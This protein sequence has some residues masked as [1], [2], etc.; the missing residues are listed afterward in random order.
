M[1]GGWHIETY[2]E[3]MLVGKVSRLLILGMILRTRSTATSALWGLVAEWL[4]GIQTYRILVGG[5]ILVGIERADNLIVQ[6][7]LDIIEILGIVWII[8][9]QILGEFQ[10]IVGAAGLVDVWICLRLSFLLTIGC[11]AQNLGVRLAEH[12]AISYATHRIHISA[13]H[14]APEVLRQIIVIRLV[15]ALVASQRS[16]NH[17][18]MLVGMASTDVVDVLAQWVEELR[19]IKTVGCLDE[20]CLLLWIGN[21]L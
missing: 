14:Q 4:G 9:V 3:R 21:H 10:E 8:A 19:G 1:K 11:H 18:D 7:T 2:P 17:R 5:L 6:G 16:D 15:I 20:L 12:L 13:L